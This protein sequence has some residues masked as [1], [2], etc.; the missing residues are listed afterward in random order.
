MKNLLT[1]IIILTSL[2]A[3][4][5]SFIGKSYDGILNDFNT[6]FKDKVEWR[7]TQIADDSSKSLHVY[8]TSKQTTSFAFDFQ[9]KCIFYVI[10]MPDTSG[11]ERFEKHLNSKYV[12]ITTDKW[13]EKKRDVDVI[14]HVRKS[15]NKTK[16]MVFVY[17][18]NIE[19]Q[20]SKLIKNS[21]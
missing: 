14:W 21:L 9:D 12:K 7:V 17:P 3:S 16:T 15:L 5:Q 4:A 8:F 2:Y 10:V 6:T 19:T 13:L 11:Q 18:Q 20:I 1:V